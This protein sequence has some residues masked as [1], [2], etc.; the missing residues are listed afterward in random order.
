M[1]IPRIDR[2]RDATDRAIAELAAHGDTAAKRKLVERLLPRVRT[3][4]H[5]LSPGDSE[6]DDL[7]QITLIEILH[8]V[9][10]FRGESRLETWAAKIAVRTSMHHLKARQKLLGLFVSRHDFEP[11]TR[12]TPEHASERLQLRRRIKALLNRLSM[13][14]RTVIVLKLVEGM[15]L[16]EIAEITDS[17]VNTVRERL[18]VGR[19]RFRKYLVQD[20]MLRDWMDRTER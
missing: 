17:P 2:D 1:A 10:T 12:A 5:Y 15:S 9:G 19:K 7:V 6:A 16:N 18:R 13:E 14:Q 8:S 4:I 20:P 3:T 11:A